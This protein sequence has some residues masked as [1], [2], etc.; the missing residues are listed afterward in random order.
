MAQPMRKVVTFRTH[1]ECPLSGTE[2]QGPK[3]CFWQILLKNPVVVWQRWLTLNF[4][5]RGLHESTFDGDIA[6]RMSL[7]RA[8]FADSQSTSIDRRV[9]QQNW[10]IAAVR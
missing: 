9:F 10:H 4:C 2:L 7:L 5:S 1:A 3:D 8:E 6:D